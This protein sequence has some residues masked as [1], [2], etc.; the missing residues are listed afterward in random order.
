MFDNDRN[1]K[2]KK[3]EMKKSDTPKNNNHTGGE[4]GDRNQR[5]DTR[6]PIIRKR[7]MLNA[8]DQRRMGCVHAYRE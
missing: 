2:R 7:I 1:Q 8:V 5:N 4:G 3:N 6:M